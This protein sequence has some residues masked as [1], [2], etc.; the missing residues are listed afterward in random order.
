MDGSLLQ[1]TIGRGELAETAIGVPHDEIG[2]ATVADFDQ[3]A[4]AGKIARALQRTAD[5]R[6]TL[7][8]DIGR[9]LACGQDRQGQKRRREETLRNHHPTALPRAARGGKPQR[10]LTCDT[11]RM[12]PRAAEV[13]I[14]A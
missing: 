12:A 13:V 14:A 3:T 4:L 1:V 9:A 5:R 11:S 7:G 6:A 8:R 2:L 10:R